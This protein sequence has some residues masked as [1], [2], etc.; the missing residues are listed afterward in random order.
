MARRLWAG[1]SIVEWRSRVLEDVG[2][3]DY[4]EDE[5]C[6]D[7]CGALVG[8][9]GASRDHETSCSLHPDSVAAS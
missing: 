4:E 8:G 2:I 7:E 5:D 6:C 1:S 9:F 3:V